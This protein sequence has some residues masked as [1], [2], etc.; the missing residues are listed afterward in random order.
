MRVSASRTPGPLIFHKALKKAQGTAMDRVKGQV[1]GQ[2]HP[3][4]PYT[5]VSVLGPVSQADVIGCL[6]SWVARGL[7]EQCPVLL[8]KI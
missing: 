1:K 4:D 3:P 2:T 7:G 6:L 5:K 8:D